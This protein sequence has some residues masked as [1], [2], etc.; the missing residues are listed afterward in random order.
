[1]ASQY[2]LGYGADGVIRTEYDLQGQGLRNGEGPASVYSLFGNWGSQYTG[3]NKQ[4]NTQSTYKFA[5]SA[6]VGDHEI[7]IRGRITPIGS[8]WCDFGPL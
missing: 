8:M 4:K 7:L 1:M 6:D 5:A 2:I 3:A